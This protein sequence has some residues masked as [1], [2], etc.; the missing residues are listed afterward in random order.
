MTFG[1]LP[2]FGEGGKGVLQFLN[3]PLPL[4]P[5]LGTPPGSNHPPALTCAG[6]GCVSEDPCAC[7]NELM[8]E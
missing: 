8:S 6:E 2:E 1:V 4:N 7:T 5:D 3:P